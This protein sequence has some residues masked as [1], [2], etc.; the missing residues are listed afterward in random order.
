MDQA[1]T[2]ADLPS[3]DDIVD[4]MEGAPS[5][6]APAETPIKP[7][8]EAPEAP[9]AAPEEK[10]AQ[11]ETPEA[12]PEPEPSK[13]EMLNQ[14]MALER[15][16]R[17]QEVKFKQKEQELKEREAQ[18]SNPD[19]LIRQRFQEKIRSGDALEA[20]EEFG[21]DFNDL[22]RAVAEAKPYPEKGVGRDDIA[23]L[24]KELEDF[25]AEQIRVQQER[26]QQEARNVVANAVKQNELMAGLGD[27][28]VE[29]VFADLKNTYAE[30]GSYSLEASIATVESQLDQFY[31]SIFDNPNLRKRY[32]AEKVD[33]NPGNAN[34]VRNLTK[35]GSTASAT[36]QE[37]DSSGPVNPE[38][39]IEWV[40][41]RN[42]N[43]RK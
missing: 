43:K 41:Q 19:D 2:A 10:G 14:A 8:A 9:E 4:K 7:A 21:I 24:K 12:T 42:A 3:L 37:V 13:A 30:T 35:R 40:L 31:K 29:A 17:E 18:F 15:A 27:E 28:V 36:V 6:E 34:P 16:Q 22:T 39:R 20:L 1:V 32:L 5:E 26:E 33:D 38:D 25:K 11:E 23:Q